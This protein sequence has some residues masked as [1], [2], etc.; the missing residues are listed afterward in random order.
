MWCWCCCCTGYIDPV[1]F[2]TKVTAKGPD[3]IKFDRPLPVNVRLNWKPELHKFVPMIDGACGIEFLTVQF[4]YTLYPGHF[5]V[6]GADDPL[7]NTIARS[8]RNRLMLPCST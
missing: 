4:P 7:G 3:W 1:R 5:L 2:L 8:T 6:R